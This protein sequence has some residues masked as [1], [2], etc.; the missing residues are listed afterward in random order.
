MSKYICPLCN[1]EMLDESIV[2][3][4]DIGYYSCQKCF[5][6]YDE[7][8]GHFHHKGILIYTGRFERCY[9]IYKLKAFL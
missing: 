1:N 4:E 2:F 3:P 8:T 9:K 6:R 5:I 7:F